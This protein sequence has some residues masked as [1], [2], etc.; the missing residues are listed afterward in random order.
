M[1]QLAHKCERHNLKDP[2]NSARIPRNSAS[3]ASL[4]S[5]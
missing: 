1:P 5:M 4:F 3:E 2:R